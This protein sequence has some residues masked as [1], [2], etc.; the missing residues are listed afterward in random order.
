MFR[1]ANNLSGVSEDRLESLKRQFSEEGDTGNGLSLSLQDQYNEHEAEQQAAKRQRGMMAP[2]FNAG[3]MGVMNAMNASAMGGNLPNGV[4]GAAPQANGA[5]PGDGTNNDDAATPHGESSASAPGMNAMMNPALMGANGGMMGMNGMNNMMGSPMGAPNMNMMGA[6]QMQNMMGAQQQMQNMMGAQ[7]MGA[8]QMMP[9]MNHMA[10]AAGPAA[11]MNQMNMAQQMNMAARAGMLGGMPG[12]PGGMDDLTALYLNAD[13]FQDPRTMGLL[14]SQRGGL[15]LAAMQGS[16]GGFLPGAMGAADYSLLGGNPYAGLAAGFNP[17]AA[18]AP[19]SAGAAAMGLPGRRAQ[20]MALMDMENELQQQQQEASKNGTAGGG[21]FPGAAGPNGQ[22]GGWAAAQRNPNAAAAVAPG[23][24]EDP[25][26]MDQTQSAPTQIPEPPMDIPTFSTAST[27]SHLPLPP[28]IEEGAAAHYS[29]RSHIPLGIDEDNNWLTEFQCFIRFDL[30]EVVQASRHVD[31]MNKNGGGGNNGG[32]GNGETFQQVGVRCRYCAHLHPGQRASRSSAFPSSIRQLYQSFTMMLRDHFEQ[33]SEIPAIRKKLFSEL[34]AKN[35]QGAYD[36]K[37]YWIYA[38]E[39]LGMVD[40]EHGIQMTADSQA[41]ARRK[42]PFGSVPPATTAAPP[43][44]LVSPD[45]IR[46]TSDFLYT[47]MSSVQVVHLIDSERV[48]KRKTLRV[49]LPG[50]GCRYCCHVGRCGLSRMFPL[51]RR[52]LPGK[53]NEIYEHV[54]RCTLFPTK[55]KERLARLK[56][57]DKTGPDQE[58]E[59]FDR[60]WERLGAESEVKK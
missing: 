16:M 6:Q 2:E 54:K 58:K 37:Q 53:V 25:N 17:A 56:A 57:E 3:A 47:L 51:R 40:S 4:G 11:A 59:F 22:D 50:F 15:G 34:K 60:I 41:V 55:E 26:G 20:L 9:G 7:M 33:C 24:R 38:A 35:S 27:P 21:G 1:G 42:S 10:G 32:N 48:G 13:A 28:V 44:L 52:M 39:K 43:K 5:L 19:G 49:G 8:G 18:G 23:R 45:D 36:S 29:Q 46:I 31:Q 30:I 14:A 12:A